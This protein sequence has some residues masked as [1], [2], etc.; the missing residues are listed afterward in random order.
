MGLYHWSVVTLDNFG[1]SKEWPQMFVSLYGASSVL[2]Y[3]AHLAT[4][5]VGKRGALFVSIMAETETFGGQVLIQGD[6]ASGW[7]AWH[8][9]AGVFW[10][11]VQ[12]YFLIVYSCLWK[13]ILPPWGFPR[14]M[15]C[16]GNNSSRGLVPGHAIYV[17]ALRILDAWSINSPN[18]WRSWHSFC[19]VNSNTATYIVCAAR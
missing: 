18:V 15:P 11:L 12:G 16:D 3:V 6:I 17:F 19:N 2:P 1:N 10:L 9:N 8:E 13:E 7:R 4:V 14:Q 5:C